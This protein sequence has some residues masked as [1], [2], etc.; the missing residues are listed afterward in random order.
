MNQR[1]RR[2][3]RGADFEALELRELRQV[4]CTSVGELGVRET[5]AFEVGQMI[6]QLLQ[7]C[8]VNAAAAMADFDELGEAVEPGVALPVIAVPTNKKDSRFVSPASCAIPA[9]VSLPLLVKRR[10]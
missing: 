3:L 8:V 9:S 2:G 6:A 5:D 7:T 10:V 1:L 4:R